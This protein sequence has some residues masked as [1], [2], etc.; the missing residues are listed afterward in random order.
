MRHPVQTTDQP[1]HEPRSCAGHS[2]S[3]DRQG[4]TGADRDQGAPPLRSA[5]SRWWGRC[6]LSH[7]RGEYVPCLG[8]HAPSVRGGPAS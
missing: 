8:F 3:R 2:G 1:G 7:R 6:T 5:D 4:D